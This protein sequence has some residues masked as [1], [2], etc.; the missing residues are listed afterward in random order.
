ALGIAVDSV[1]SAYVTG[2]TSSANFPTTTGTF[3]TANAGAYDAFVTKLNAAGTGLVYST[4]LGGGGGDFGQGIAVDSM[5]SAYVT[6]GTFS[7]NF[8]T[9]TG[10]FRTANTGN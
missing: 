8:P 2:K 1:G 5:G 6:G 9:T 10:A 3:Q 4:Y 7:K